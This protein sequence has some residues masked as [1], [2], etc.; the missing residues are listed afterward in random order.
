MENKGLIH[1]SNLDKWVLEDFKRE[2]EIL[3]ISLS[4]YL[5]FKIYR[6]LEKG[7]IISQ[8]L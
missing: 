8:E 6:E 5:L 7:V 2:A 1:I 4:E 3:D